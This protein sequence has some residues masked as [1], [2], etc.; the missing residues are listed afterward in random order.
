[1]ERR[2]FFDE[3]AM[4]RERDWFL[5]FL[6]TSKYQYKHLDKLFVKIRLRIYTWTNYI[7][8]FAVAAVVV[9][10]RFLAYADFQPSIPANKFIREDWA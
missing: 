5:Y 8:V 4:P 9:F 3:V 10:V 1:M 7:S 2:R 6:N